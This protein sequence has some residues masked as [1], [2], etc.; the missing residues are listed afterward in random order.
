[1][2]KEEKVLIE[3]FKNLEKQI[4]ETLESADITIDEKAD[5]VTTKKNLKNYIGKI[6]KAKK[7]FDEYERVAKD[8]EKISSD[9]EKTDGKLSE[10]VVDMRDVSPETAIEIQQIEN[11]VIVKKKKK[12]SGGTAREL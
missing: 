7:L 10:A 2:K 5:E 12:N 1:M 9:A 11:S 4:I 3:V 8:I 6:N